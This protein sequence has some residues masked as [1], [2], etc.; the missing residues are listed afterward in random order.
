MPVS[1]AQPAA[2]GAIAA[3]RH[4]KPRVKRRRRVMPLAVVYGLIPCQV[5]AFVLRHLPLRLCLRAG[6][7][8]YGEPL[9]AT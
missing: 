6:L 5:I 9:P 7:F 8:G 3:R 1:V 4:W 2:F